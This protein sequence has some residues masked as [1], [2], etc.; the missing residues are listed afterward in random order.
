MNSP[1]HQLYPKHSQALRQAEL[2]DDETTIP[3]LAE[4]LQDVHERESFHPQPKS[5]KV[6]TVYFCMAATPRWGEPPWLKLTHLQTTHEMSWI[7]VRMSYHRH[8]NLRELLGSDLETKVV[9]GITSR[10]FMRE[11][12]NCRDR[13][14]VGCEGQDLLT[15][16]ER[17]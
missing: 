3:T 2:I 11:T 7:N 6:N 12:C 13:E 1:M 9:D 16:S 4:A 8:P 17:V 10:D 5:P 15:C 14:T